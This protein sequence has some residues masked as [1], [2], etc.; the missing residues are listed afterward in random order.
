M[1]NGN[2]AMRVRVGIVGCG[3]I[4]TEICEA[5]DHDELEMELIFLIDK[6]PERIRELVN[7]LKRRPKI[8]RSGSEG[9]SEMLDAVDLVIECASQ[10]AV[11][12][13]V[14]PA[15]HA[16][17]DVMI[18]SVGAL[19]C[20]EGLFEEIVNIARAGGS[21]VY[22]PSGAIAGLDG[23]K[24]GAI[25][26]I[27]SVELRTRKPPRGFAGNTYLRAQGVE[28]SVIEHEETLFVG[29][30]RDAVRYFPENVNVAASLSIAGIGPD[31]TMVK[32]I[33]DPTIAENVHEIEVKG[34]FGK[35]FVRVE[36]VPSPMNPKT[37]HLAALSAIATLRGITYPVRVGT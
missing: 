24:S 30:A 8:T 2:R 9:L 15:L 7:R 28:L 17:K 33:A 14:I 1:V 34:E 6:H 32:I 18:M 21:R 20:D 22:I 3:S 36:N 25:G 26:S 19:I 35:L 5:I 13:Y 11:R 10:D 4:G 37:S 16:G 12:E 29:P 31:S 27:E 23:L